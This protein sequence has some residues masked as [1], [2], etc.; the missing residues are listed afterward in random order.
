MA[1]LRLVFSTG[2][3]SGA[4]PTWY[5]SYGTFALSIEKPPLPSVTARCEARVVSAP[6]RD[7]KERSSYGTFAL[8]AADVP[9]EFVSVTD[10]DAID[11]TLPPIVNGTVSENCEPVGNDAALAYQ[12][13]NRAP[14]LMVNVPVCS[15]DPAAGVNVKVALVMLSVVDVPIT[16]I[17]RP[18]VV[19]ATAT[20]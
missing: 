17:C 20:L 11:D 18:V 6:S 15:V 2:G 4:L 3:A 13:E 5:R 8:A 7:W 14:T 16:V 19:V 12:A 10:T 9:A 1:R